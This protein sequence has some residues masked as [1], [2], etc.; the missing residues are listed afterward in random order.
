MR[1]DDREG[2]PIGVAGDNANSLAG[3]LREAISELERLNRE[4]EQAFLMVGGKMAASIEAVKFMSSGLESVAGLI[5]GE[6]GRNAAQA[7]NRVLDL[8]RGMGAR[9]GA[10]SGLLGNISEEGKRLNK[11]LSQ[12]EGVVASFHSL[13]LLTR[14]ETA[15]LGK[16]SADFGNLAEDVRL[17]ARNVETRVES[18]LDTAGELT[19]R[20]ESALRDVAALQ[21][22]QARELPLVIDQVLQSLAA[23]GEMQGLTHDASIR[24]ASESGEIAGAFQRLI[25]SMQ[26]QDITR[27]Q[28]EHVID[29]LRRL[30]S[31]PGRQSGTAAVILELQLS[32][33]S[34]ASG[35]FSDS[36]A[37]VVASLGDIA[38]HV[39][40][41]A[42]GSRALSGRSGTNSSFQ[43][44]ERGCGAILASFGQCAHADAATQEMSGDLAEAVA[45]M[46]RSI[47]EI[48]TIEG[49]MRRTAMNAMISAEHLGQKGEALGALADSIR[50]K[51]AESRQASEALIQTLDAMNG[52]AR[53]LSGQERTAVERAAQEEG[54]E[55]MRTA[56]TQLS[57]SQEN[58]FK[59]IKEIATRAESLCQDLAEA[60]DG[61]SIGA[62]FAATVNGLQNSLKAAIEEMRRGLPSESEEVLLAGLAELA[63]R[64]TMQEQHDIHAN[65]TGAMRVAGAPVFAGEPY[66]VV[67][68][69]EFGENVELF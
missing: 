27:Q 15:R 43:Q 49:Q 10:D 29:V 54:L 48:Q 56:T 32:Q 60:R 5:S 20:I 61:L 23:F 36:V 68:A 2:F 40:K 34:H 30:S 35:K 52:G 16:A 31:A 37:E 42:D 24:L 22:G 17:L 33:L 45:R 41:M 14:I 4:T 69:G 67:D 1:L 63:G 64:Y 9:G 53:R 7:L 47:E 25:V 28:V 11:T 62:E 44:M 51:A 55:A 6:Q 58:S 39:V 57:E 18:A 21:E 50:Q 46:R 65:V 26:F 38:G 66:A 13:G 3:T 8:A 59:Q 12:F 19:P